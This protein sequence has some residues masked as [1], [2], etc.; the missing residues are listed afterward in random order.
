M[1]DQSRQW[2][3]SLREIRRDH[4]KRYEFA[5]KYAKGRT[6]DAACG[7]GYGS[8][9]LHEATQDVVGVDYNSDALSWAKRHFRGPN[10]IYGRI[11]ESPWEGKF[12]TIV[13]LETIE[14]IQNPKEALKAFWRACVGKLVVSVPNEDRYPFYPEKF[15]D[16]DSPHFRHY[17]PYELEELLR[18]CGFE[19][20]ERF[21]QVS[22]H[23]PDLVPGT[24]GAFLVYVCV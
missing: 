2:G 8:S 17:R 23:L 13:S 20:V 5:S 3:T 6:L 9:I 7:C 24:D 21:C 15:K 14:H 1:L 22:K 18:E 16:D 19:V 10:Y 11:E 4:V 12:E